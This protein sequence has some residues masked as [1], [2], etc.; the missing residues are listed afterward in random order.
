MYAYIHI[1]YKVDSM[2]IST[3]GKTVFSAATWWSTNGSGLF[4][5]EQNLSRILGTRI[6]WWYIWNWPNYQRYKWNSIDPC[7]LTTVGQQSATTRVP[8]SQAPIRLIHV[9]IRWGTGIHQDTSI[10][11][12]PRFFVKKKVNGDTVGYSGGICEPI[13]ANWNNNTIQACTH[14]TAD[15][16]RQN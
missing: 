10:L 4:G 7:H 1:Y 8:T 15:T 11:E 12:Y 16:N 14:W 2:N 13:R 6:F 5:P 3:K 9:L